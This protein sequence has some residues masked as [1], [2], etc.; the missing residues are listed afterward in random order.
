MAARIPLHA[1]Q[2]KAYDI[3]PDE[4]SSWKIGPLWIWAVC[5]DAE[6]RFAWD[7]VEDGAQGRKRMTPPPE[8]DW[9]RCATGETGTRLKFLPVL[10]D[11]FLSTKLEAPLR[12]LSGARIRL[13]IH[14]PVWVRILLPEKQGCI[15]GELATRVLT[16]SWTGDV[17]GG[18]PCYA[19]RSRAPTTVDEGN[20]PPESVT[21]PVELVNRAPDDLTVENILLRLP[22]LGIYTARGTL[23]TDTTHII[24][25]GPGEFESVQEDG[26]LPVECAGGESLSVPRARPRAGLAALRFSPLKA[27]SEWAF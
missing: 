16:R 8:T 4:V 21:S 20:L 6:W 19:K 10:P 17:T 3:E 14:V 2:W 27:I 24:Y 7:R 18:E 9:A 26:T 12:I 25:K 11:L 1:L 15:L 22:Y 5:T 13:F 23:W